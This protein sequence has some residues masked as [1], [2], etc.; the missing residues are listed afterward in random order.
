MSREQIVEKHRSIIKEAHSKIAHVIVQSRTDSHIPTLTNNW[1]ILKTMDCEEILKTTQSWR[2]NI[3]LPLVI[4]NALEI[5]HR[6]TKKK[7]LLERWK[8]ILK[9]SGAVECEPSIVYKKL[10]VAIRALYSFLRIMPSNLLVKDIRKKNSTLTEIES[11][12][13]SSNSTLQFG[14]AVREFELQP[15]PTPQGE[16]A[17]SVMYLQD[18]P[19]REYIVPDKVQLDNIIMDYAPKASIDIPVS[20][21][22]EV[23]G[24]S[25]TTP[26]SLERYGSFN[27]RRSSSK[28]NAGNS[29][30][31]VGR[32]S[33]SSRSRSISN[34]MEGEPAIGRLGSIGN[35]ISGGVVIPAPTR[36]DSLRGLASIAGS[37]AMG[38]SP[39]PRQSAGR[40]SVEFTQG[41]L[42]RELASFNRNAD[43][44]SISSPQRSNDGHYPQFTSSGRPLYGQTPPQ[45]NHGTSWN[46][47]SV[48][49]TSPPMPSST[50]PF[51]RPIP[52]YEGVSVDDRSGC[53]IS[54][55]PPTYTGSLPSSFKK[56]GSYTRP[57]T[58]EP[59]KNQIGNYF[60]DPPLQM[61]RGGD[62]SNHSSLGNSSHTDDL[63][64]SVERA[65]SVPSLKSP[66]V[67]GDNSCEL[68]FGISSG[69]VG[70][71]IGTFVRACRGQPVLNRSRVE[72][73][74]KLFISLFEEANNL[75]SVSKTADVF[76]V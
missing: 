25:G 35:D 26:N 65:T 31:S 4:E 22:P 52:I 1:F 48:L 68:V 28:S 72:V 63:V 16:Y 44:S 29:F 53:S 62:D 10:L 66:P 7:I 57:L 59:A 18:C 20:R 39:I 50:P 27:P 41:S 76:G 51:S 6:G 64:G 8:I 74:Q 69:S 67:F 58:S 3:H 55:S 42:A 36:R 60:Q 30:G 73:N 45:H 11:T 37:P 38:V 49:A 61:L 33:I 14:G 43:P 75:M 32:T 12:I 46:N 40:A 2:A 19:F 15:I 9:K 24:D 71:D 34:P 70:V 56:S 23:S 54:I 17:I 13:S 47:S 21:T 5:S